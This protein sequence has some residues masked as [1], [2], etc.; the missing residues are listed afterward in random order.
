MNVMAKDSEEFAGFGRYAGPATL[1]LASLADGTKHGYALTKDIESFAGVRLA[2]GTLYEAL[3]RLEAQGMIEAVESHGTLR[4]VEAV[5]DKDLAS[6]LLARSIGADLFVLAT[7]VERVALGFNTPQQR[8]L[9]RMTLDEAK[10]YDAADE[11]DRGSMG[12]KIKALIEF[13]DGGG[14]RGLIT[15]PGSLCRALSGETGT[16]MVP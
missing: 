7:G 8:W 9:D 2:P 6:S 16:V 10:R 13:L 5:I 4:G 12:P 11:F 15:A 3:A 14:T 1:I